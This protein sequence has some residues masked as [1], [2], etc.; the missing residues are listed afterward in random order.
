MSFWYLTNIMTSEKYYQ[1][2]LE[3]IHSHVLPDATPQS[4]NL[5][6]VSALLSDPVLIACFQEALRLQSQNSSVR[7]VQE[8]TTLPVLGKEYYLRKGSWVF[9]PAQLIHLD[10]EIYEN[11]NVFEPDRF[12]ST[13]LE[14]TLVFTNEQT[15]F[16]GS[17]EAEKK[18]APKFLKRGVPVKHYMM[19]FGGGD[20]LVPIITFVI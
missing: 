12:L 15:V 1:P 20:N 9:I 13:D 4:E 3:R 18:P 7:A 2:I 14:S 10:P 19:P 17:K 11:V 5:F 16:K 6:N 8:D